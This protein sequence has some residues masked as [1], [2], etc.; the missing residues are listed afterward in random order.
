MES[1]TDPATVAAMRADPITPVETIIFTFSTSRDFNPECRV[2]YTPTPDSTSTDLID[3][4]LNDPNSHPNHK[5]A[6]LP[7]PHL[8]FNHGRRTN[9]DATSLV[10][11]TK[12]FARTQTV[13]SFLD[14]GDLEHRTSSFRS[15]LSS[16][17][18]A[19][20]LGGR[21]TGS[22]SATRAQIWSPARKLIFFTYPLT[23]GLSERY[24]EL[25]Q[26]EENVHVLF[27]VGDSDPLC[28]ELHLRAIRKR[29]RAKTW[30]IRVINGD[31]LFMMKG[32]KEQETKMCDIAGQIAA[33]WNV[34]GGRN[35][36]LTELMLDYDIEKKEVFWSE[37]ERDSEM[38]EDGGQ[39]VTISL[40]ISGGN[41][42]GGG[43]SFVRTIPG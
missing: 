8:I 4:V 32:D 36:E 39:P 24:E 37:W 16:F 11:F 5:A 23:R 38:K 6:S 2:C 25:M 27:V 22:R 34:D 29:M 30:W 31:H 3:Q 35:T 19:L 15:L 20:T 14:L 28:H 9:L 10:A 26:L 42:S 33:R 43:E 21:S 12:G 41:L 18:T 17:P 7:Q 13:L 40:T 1:L